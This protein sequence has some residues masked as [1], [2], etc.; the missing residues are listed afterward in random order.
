VQLGRG[1]VLGRNAQRARLGAVDQHAR[2]VIAFE[3]SRYREVIAEREYDRGGLLR[4]AP[5]VAAPLKRKPADDTFQ[6]LVVGAP[7]RDDGS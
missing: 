7:R 4:A 6:L 1:D 5:I 3:L 2:D